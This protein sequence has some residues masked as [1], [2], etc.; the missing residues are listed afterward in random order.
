MRSRPQTRKHVDLSLADA[1]TESRFSEQSVPRND[2]AEQRLACE[3][4]SA[5]A[6]VTRDILE[7]LGAR[8]ELGSGSQAAQRAQLTDVEHVVGGARD[9][10]H[11]MRIEVVSRPVARV[12][13]SDAGREHV[14]PLA[15][16]PYR[17]DR[18]RGRPRRRG[19][20]RG[21]RCHRSGRTTTGSSDT[22]R[23]R[24][25]R[26]A[27]RGR[28]PPRPERRVARA[29]GARPLPTTLR[30]SRDAAERADSPPA[31][32]PSPIA[33]A[34][35]AETCAGRAPRTRA[36]PGGGPP[37]PG[38]SRGGVPLQAPTRASAPRRCPGIARSSRA[39]TAPAR[40]TERSA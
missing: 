28:R 19:N 13:S 31:P 23:R 6:R 37:A 40:R 11:E 27:R 34:G 38:S 7:A 17:P 1:S 35:T 15:P 21:R 9:V 5:C 30:R 29:R 20:P 12:P 24:G 10:R 22:P 4:L 18:R 25:R 32:G 26:R 2:D 39:P 8:L 36:H 14:E 33:T 16:Q 3:G